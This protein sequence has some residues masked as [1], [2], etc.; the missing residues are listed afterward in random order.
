MVL[1]FDD[2]YVRTGPGVPVTAQRKNCQKNINLGN[3]PAGTQ[4]S[5]VSVLYSGYYHL[6]ENVTATVKDTVYFSGSRSL[7]FLAVSAYSQGSRIRPIHLR[8]GIRRS[9]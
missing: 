3:I 6:E 9:Q 1:K 5:V 2:Y 7:S 8:A 4:Y